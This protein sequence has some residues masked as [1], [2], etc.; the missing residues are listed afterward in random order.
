MPQKA[1]HN[2]ATPLDRQTILAQLPTQPGVYRLLD[3]GDAVLYVGKA[4]NLKQRVS[5][6]FRARLDSAKTTALMRQVVRVEVTLTA[7]ENE[8]LLLESNLIKQLKPRFNVLLRDD[9][10]YPYVRLTTQTDFPRLDFYRGAKQGKDRYFGPYPS[11]HAVRETLTLLQKIFKLRQCSEVFF[12]HRQRP[13][14]QYFIQRCTAPCVGRIDKKSYQQNV[15]HAVM[16]LEGK[17]QALIVDITKRMEQHSAKLEY[18]E[19]AKLRNQI[20]SLRRVQEKQYINSESGSVDIIAVLR[21]GHYCC[22]Q[23]LYIRDG[24][25]LGDKSFYPELKVEATTEDIISDF[26]PQ[27]YLNTARNSTIPKCVMV[28]VNLADKAWIESALSERL[29]VSF[30]IVTS[31]RGKWRQWMILAEKNAKHAL[32]CLITTK[33]TALQRLQAL[34]PA[35]KLATLPVRLECFDVSH[36]MGTATVASCVV[37]DQHG[38]VKKDYRR[39]NITGITRGDDYAALQQALTRR[40]TRLKKAEQALPDVLLI[41][42]GKGQ[43]SVAEQVVQE[44]QLSGV[45]LFA[46]AKGPGRKPGLEVIFKQGSRQP[47]HLPAD[48]AALH[49]LQTMRD[50]AHRFAITGHRQQ[51][52]KALSHSVLQDIPGIGPKRRQAVLRHFGGM[53]ALKQA[54]LEALATVPGMSMALAKKLHEFLQG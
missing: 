11:T 48:S 19:A 42:G 8:A 32:E 30:K 37:F 35:L 7:T 21:H 27:Y 33:T 3:A 52:R 47:I 18:E 54:R 17:S 29:G 26:L 38:A 5:H 40:Y 24:R 34:Q 2:P 41:D 45:T 13:C 10:S 4:K 28:N 16:F 15:R 36:T 50:E 22:V 9:K 44:C 23:V 6:Y 43:L 46:I 14:L 25:L 12:R 49:F 53:Q 39:Y 20:T 1:Q 51:R 31:R